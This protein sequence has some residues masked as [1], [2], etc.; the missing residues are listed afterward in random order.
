MNKR[1][2]LLAS[3]VFIFIMVA[4]VTSAEEISKPPTIE[5]IGKAKIMTMPN[6]ATISFSVETNAAKAQQAIAENAERTDV[7]LKTLKNS[8][9]KSGKVKTTNFNVSP[10][11]GKDDRLRPRGYRVTNTVFLETKSMNRLGTLI[12]EASRAGVSRI[13]S[14]IF[15]TDKEEEIRRQAATAAVRNAVKTAETLAKAAGLTIQKIIKVSYMPGEPV[16]PYRMEAMAAASRTPIEIGEI[17]IEER[18][19]VV[20]EAN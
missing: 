13:G 20:F 3:V 15:T 8:V 14:L 4:S 7:L 10:V 17:P 1:A 11:Y 2:T 19:T 12:D 9:G 18:V 6:M 5:V 16:R